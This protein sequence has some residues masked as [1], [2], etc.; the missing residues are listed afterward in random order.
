M[1]DIR[2]RD[3]DVALEETMRREGKTEDMMKWG[4]IERER[5]RKKR[6]GE[7][8]ISEKRELVTDDNVVAWLS[9][10]YI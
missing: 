6:E 4:E 7:R 2:R 8:Y 3:G 1:M 9:S 10:L 5:K